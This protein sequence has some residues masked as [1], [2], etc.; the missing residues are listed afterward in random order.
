MVY[1]WAGAGPVYSSFSL[2][3]ASGEVRLGRAGA[4]GLPLPATLVVRATQRDN[5]D[6]YSR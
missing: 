4:G 1:S 3:A 6:R 2:D 5:P